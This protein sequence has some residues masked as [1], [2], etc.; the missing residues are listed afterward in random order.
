MSISVGNNAHLS[1]AVQVRL[2]LYGFGYRKE[3]GVGRKTLK[4]RL[5]KDIGSICAALDKIPRYRRDEAITSWFKHHYKVIKENDRHII[6]LENHKSAYAFGKGEE[7]KPDYRSCILHSNREA[8]YDL[9]WLYLRG[10]SKQRLQILEHYL[11]KANRDCIATIVYVHHIFKVD[12]LMY[13][14]KQQRPRT[15]ELIEYGKLVRAVVDQLVKE[16]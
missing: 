5:F 6:K 7:Y 8:L 4:K 15:I 10:V 3:E 12:C 16:P 9:G 1:V 13:M 11:S 14:A 2:F